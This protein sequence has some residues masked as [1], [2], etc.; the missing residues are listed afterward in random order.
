M[1][2]RAHTHT[3]TITTTTPTLYLA[4]QANGSAYGSARSPVCQ[5]PAPPSPQVDLKGADGDSKKKACLYYD[6][7]S[8]GGQ[9]RPPRIVAAQ[10][11]A[12]SAGPAASAAAACTRTRVAWSAFRRR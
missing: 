9:V 1:R 7:E 10:W 2:A 6:G 8:V 3:T 12:R 5:T 11:R 4:E